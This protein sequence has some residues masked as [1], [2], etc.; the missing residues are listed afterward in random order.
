MRAGL[1]LLPAA[2]EAVKM[3]TFVRAPDG[4][5]RACPASS[6]FQR[7]INSGAKD[8]LLD[9]LEKEISHSE[10][11]E[12]LV[13]TNTT[14]YST[15]TGW[16][17]MEKAGHTNVE[18]SRKGDPLNTTVTMDISDQTEIPDE[19]EEDESPGYAINFVVNCKNSSGQELKF[20][21]SYFENSEDD[22]SIEHICCVPDGDEDKDYYTGPQFTELDEGLKKEFSKFLKEK[23]VNAE[24]GQCLCTLMYDKEQVEYVK[25]MK[26]V[27]SFFK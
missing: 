6:A 21:M 8:S 1:R 11:D 14:G 12:D 9:S 26:R 23:G 24:L 19:V 2:I 20:D 22:P 10:E 7:Y 15:P 17:L 27:K 13:R 3:Q 5:L 4:V 16:D 25:W 18:L